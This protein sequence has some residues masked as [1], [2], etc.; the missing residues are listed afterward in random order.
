[1]QD[2]D[3][4]ELTA[5]QCL[6]GRSGELALRWLSQDGDIR[7]YTYQDLDR[8][9]ERY[10]RM[11]RRLGLKAGEVVVVMTGRRPE[12]VFAALGIWKAGG[13]YCPV[14]RDLGPDPL[15]VRLMLC[16][17]RILITDGGT[18]A[19][20]VAMKRDL[21]NHLA[22]VLLTGEAGAAGT[23]SLEAE[24][25]DET[26]PPMPQ[27]KRGRSGVMHFTSGTTAAVA[28]GLAQPKAVIHDGTLVAAIA[29]S[30]SAAFSLGSQD[31]LW[32]TAE[33]GWV[34]H[35]AY[36]II[37]PLACGAAI[38][39]DEAMPRPTRCLSVLEDQPVSVWYTSPSVIRCLIGAGAAPARRYRPR[40]LRLAASVGEPLSPDA[41]EWGATVLG[42][43]FRDTWWQTETGAIVLAHD[44]AQAPRPGSMG[45]AVPGM[46]LALASRL[47]D[48]GMAI[49]GG[50]GEGLGE[51][52][53]KADHL[54][55][56]RCLGGEIG[57]IP[58]E[59]DG[60]H[61]TG[62]RVRR[63]AEGYFWFLG[64]KDD[65]IKSAG[66]TIGP[67]EVEA[68]LMSHPAVAEAGVVGGPDAKLNQRIVAF[69]AVNP[70]FEPGAALRCELWA[71]ARDHLGGGLVPHE[72]YFAQDL[73]RTPSGK[74][75]RRYLRE[76]LPTVKA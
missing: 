67:F 12:T 22:E 63:D 69:V 3:P 70:G 14:F 31:M 35:S 53:V 43:P 49:M 27:N 45:R 20:A 38:L 44:P 5:I 72:I 40:A 4:L 57:R 2:V 55:A 61:L 65:V 36:G 23:R 39:L 16:K 17:G 47:D 19:T 75:I 18:Y 11:L 59:I 64:R 46:L 41:V 9:A 66:R 71:Y 15:F 76:R 60:W 50:T 37:A 62:D 29:A 7:D 8:M 33:P 54:P 24:L 13:V 52:A 28:G 30:A 26:D 74:I 1:M 56:W 58:E 73:P 25:A 6:G 10:A 34:T 48:G 68:V 32:C 21:L 51:L 42:V